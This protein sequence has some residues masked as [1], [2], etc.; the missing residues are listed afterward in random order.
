MPNKTKIIKKVKIPNKYVFDFLRGHL[1]GDGSFYSY[2]DPRWRSS[3]MFY[4]TFVSASHNHIQWLRK[5]IK[6]FT[7]AKGHITSARKVGVYYQLKYAKSESLIIL[8]KIYAHTDIYLKR[9]KLKINK[10]LSIIGIAL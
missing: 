1:D 4:T 5:V 3:Y 8:R 6:K 2:Y 9:K 7:G 10:A